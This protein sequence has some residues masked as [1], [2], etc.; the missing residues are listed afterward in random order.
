MSYGRTDRR[1][2]GP[3]RYCGIFLRWF[4]TAHY[5]ITAQ[6]LRR[7]LSR[8]PIRNS[9]CVDQIGKSVSSFHQ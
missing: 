8:S 9:R 1:T 3:T 2:D 7:Q 5:H 6:K 4:W